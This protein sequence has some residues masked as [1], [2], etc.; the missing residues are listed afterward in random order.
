MLAFLF[1]FYSFFLFSFAALN[2]TVLLKTKQ[3]WEQLSRD[4][5]VTEELEPVSDRVPP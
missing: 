3:I 5:T 2:T 4:H 1:L